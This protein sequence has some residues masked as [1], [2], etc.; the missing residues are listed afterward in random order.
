MKD[1]SLKK[2]EQQRYLYKVLVRKCCLFRSV[3]LSLTNGDHSQERKLSDKRG[4]HGERGVQAYNGGMDALPLAGS[5]PI[6]SPE[7]VARSLCH[8]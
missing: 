4:A 3:V 6:E 7:S 8:S 1:K 2:Y 5:T